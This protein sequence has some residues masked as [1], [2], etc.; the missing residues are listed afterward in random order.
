MGAFLYSKLWGVDSKT[1]NPDRWFT[2]DAIQL[3][4]MEANIELI[5]SYGKWQCLGKNITQ[6]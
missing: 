4:Q 3:K 5:F 6:M 2:R 1:F